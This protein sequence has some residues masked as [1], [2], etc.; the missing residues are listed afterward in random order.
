MTA[1][2]VVDTGKNAKI[3]VPRD[4]TVDQDHVDQLLEVATGDLG[5]PGWEGSSWNRRAILRGDRLRYA[6]LT[7]RLIAPHPNLLVEQYEPEEAIA[8]IIEMRLGGLQPSPFPWQ[9]AKTPPLDECR[10]SDN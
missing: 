7:P 4:S 10:D 8:L 2:K 1:D 5:H 6:L 3:L 9:D